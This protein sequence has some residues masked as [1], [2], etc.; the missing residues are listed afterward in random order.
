MT[1]G[2]HIII[3]ARYES[4]RLP[5]KL[6]MDLGGQTVIE[7]VYRQAQQARPAS[8][9]IATDND[10]LYDV[11][12][13]FGATVVMTSTAHQSGTDRI[14]EVVANGTYTEND[15]IVNVQADEP[16][17]EPKLITQLAECMQTALAPMATLCWPVDEVSQLHNPNVVKVVRD[18]H[19]HALYFSRSLI[20]A[21]R[22]G[23]E[24][25]NHVY[26]HIGLYAYR[27]HF[28]L[29]IVDWPVCELETIEGLEQLRVL[30]QGHTILVEE[31]CTKPLQDINTEDD[32]LTARQ[33]LADGT[34][35]E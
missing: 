11:A 29:K 14:A 25:L 19:H 28:L 12:S 5:G 31:A 7:R 8:L 34:P 35:S 23:A 10:E 16:F 9:V 17:I 20:P 33:L 24:S 13:G 26:R 32:L 30:G 6:L 27:A 3:P 15:I 2:F 4:S 22:D 1:G 18:C 21:R